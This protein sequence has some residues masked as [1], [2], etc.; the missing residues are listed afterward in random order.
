MGDDKADLEQVIDEMTFVFDDRKIV[1]GMSS[2]PLFKNPFVYEKVYD[3][4][5]RLV[6]NNVKQS[7]NPFKDFYSMA[8]RYVDELKRSR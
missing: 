5:R 4:D 1:I 2:L 6:E 7:D 8:R 3:N